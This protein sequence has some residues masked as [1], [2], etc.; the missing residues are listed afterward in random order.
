MAGRRRKKRQSS[1]GR[2][3]SVNWYLMRPCTGINGLCPPF[4]TWAQLNDGTYSLAD[5]EM[6]NQA[7][8]EI[9]DAA[10]RSK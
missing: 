1:S 8:D 7:M 4:C 9:I 2:P 3:S 5:V 10:E 6:F